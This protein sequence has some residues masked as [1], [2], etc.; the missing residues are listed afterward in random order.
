MVY[1]TGV[2]P[3]SKPHM[4][5]AGITDLRIMGDSSACGKSVYGRMHELSGLPITSGSQVSVKQSAGFDKHAFW[6]TQMAIEVYYTHCAPMRMR[7]SQGGQSGGM[8]TA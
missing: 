2:R 1:P 4:G 6:P 8:V 7:R 3:F 5:S